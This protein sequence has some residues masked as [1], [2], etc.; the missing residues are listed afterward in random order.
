MRSLKAK[1]FAKVN[2]FLEV[3]GKRED[4]YHLLDTVMQSVSLYDKISVSLTEDNDIKVV[5]D[6]DKLSGKDNIVYKACEEFF[7][8]SGWHSGITI[9]ISKNIPVA[10]GTGGGSADAATVLNLLNKLSGKNYSLDVLCSLALKLGADVPFCIV[11]GT[12]RAT[13]VGEKLERFNT[14]KLYLAMLKLGTKKSTKEM[15]QKIDEAEKQT[16]YSSDKLISGIN[17]NNLEVIYKNIYNAFEVCWDFDAFLEIFKPYPH[18]AVFLSGSGPTVCALFDNEKD[19][20]SSV[21]D[22]KSRGFTA[23]FA[24]FTDTAF[25]IE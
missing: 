20:F 19:A 9:N 22:L 15:Y 2:L 5:C 7:T 18:K 16:V 1:A 3:T 4:G 12:A 24:A 25:E 17:D 14:P 13:G 6:D 21:C 23:N 8:F 11:G 10:A